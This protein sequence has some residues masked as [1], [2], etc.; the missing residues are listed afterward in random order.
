MAIVETH[1]ERIEGLWIEG[2]VLDRHLISS[3]SIG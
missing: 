2:F 1:P 3:G